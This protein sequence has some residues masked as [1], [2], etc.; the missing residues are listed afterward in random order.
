MKRTRGTLNSTRFAFAKRPEIATFSPIDQFKGHP[1]NPRRP[2]SKRVRQIAGILHSFGFSLAVLVGPYTDLREGQLRLRA[3]KELS[4][5]ERRIP[6]R[7]RK[8]KGDRT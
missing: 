6:L 7:H 4:S 3:F 1:R 2:V 8:I 5:T